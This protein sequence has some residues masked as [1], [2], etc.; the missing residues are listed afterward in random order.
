MDISSYDLYSIIMGG[1]TST[2][3][4][5]RNIEIIKHKVCYDLFVFMCRICVCVL[6]NGMFLNLET[7]MKSTKRK[8]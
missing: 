2:M 1:L 8:L 7:L 5:I 3:G 4:K 6:K